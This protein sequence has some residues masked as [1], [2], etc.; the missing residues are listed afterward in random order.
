MTLFN[1]AVA[2]VGI[3][4]CFFVGAY[5][6]QQQM[7]TEF[8]SMV[9][10]LVYA[11]PNLAAGVERVERLLGVKAIPG[12]QHPG[13][14]TRNALI[15]LGDE[16]YL[17]I[18]GPD[19]DQPKP[20]RPR[21]FG[22]DELQAPRLV[23]WAAKGTDL[24]AIVENAKRHGVDLGQVQSGSR[25]RPDGVLLSW[26]LTV[27]PTLNSGGI[28]PFFIDWGET[29]HPAANLPKGCA[30]VALRAEHPDADS[31]RGGLSVLGLDLLVAPG[32]VPAL[33]ATI[34]TPHGKVE[35]R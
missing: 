6:Q 27:S 33:I 19:P 29:P 28:V 34:N 8:L 31:V 24:D 32:P 14:G 25:R 22:I 30:L 7:R 23:T 15:G 11:T 4:A 16:T 9:D 26:R 3:A 1:Y 20:D 2:S 18:I 12:G 35:L 5:G 21:R 17:E 13:W 10:H